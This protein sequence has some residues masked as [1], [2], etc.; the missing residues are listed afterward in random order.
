MS[1]SER[2]KLIALLLVSVL[3]A[4]MQT[5]GLVSIMPFIAL[6]SDPTM[7]DSQPYIVW[8]KKALEL[9]DYQDLLLFFGGFSFLSLLISNSLV[10]LNYWLSLKFFNNFGLNTSTQLLKNYLNNPFKVF[11][12]HSTSQLSKRIF[13][14]IDRA[15]VGTLLAYVS[16]FT[17]I[18]T[19]IVVSGFLLY[20]NPTTTIITVAS[21]FICYLLIYFLIAKKIDGLGT[22]F[23]ADED[24]IFTRIK[25]SLVFYR[26]ISVSGSQDYFVSKYSHSAK[27]LYKG[28]T[29]FYALKFI[30]V[31]VIELTI[32]ILILILSGYLATSG[33]SIG[34]TITTISIYAFSAY[35]IVPV[36]KN[37]FDSIEEILHAKSIF[38]PLLQE[39]SNDLQEEILSAKEFELKQGLELNNI[40]FSYPGCK[41]KAINSIST[42]IN[43]G[44]L[45]CII[46]KS[47]SGKT[48]LV[49]IIL[50]L[51]EPNAGKIWIDGKVLSAK[52]TP[53][54]QQSIGYAP[55]KIHL[56]EASVL[57]NIAF[58]IPPEEIDLEK[59]Y[60]AAEYACL[61]H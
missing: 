12:K 51:I 1:K 32:F 50:G 3:N 20:I 4:L 35:R 27:A 49:D 60:L 9:N 56:L 38:T 54:W 16:L 39:L 52:D 31:Q 5:L 18:T 14:D 2:Y 34:I 46:G 21:L 47:G 30:P 25:E 61:N 36:L 58:G 17:D 53:S 15:I 22:R 41:S 10:I 24:S 57:E 28:S 33:Q 43:K 19:L 6:I 40:S 55:Q 44:E 8:L 37:I 11:Y 59:V 45:T 29:T 42:R 48:T 26:E 23:T 13:S 7:A